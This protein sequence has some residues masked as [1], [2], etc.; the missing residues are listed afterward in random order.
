MS[1]S[2][3]LKMVRDK[4]EK[5]L[6]RK[7]FED[8]LPEEIVW[9]RKDGFSDGVSSLHK[10][11]YS[12]INDYTQRVHQLSEKDYY[13][14]VFMKYYGNNQHIVPYQWLPKWSGDIKN[15]SNRL[16]IN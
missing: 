6:L 14:Q 7:T 2:P 8:R 9:R 5:Y 11:W 4:Y 16:I 10:P 15:P 3:R 1:I 13:K 12:I